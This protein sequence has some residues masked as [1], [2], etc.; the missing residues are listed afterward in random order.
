MSGAAA[1]GV[2]PVILCARIGRLACFEVY[3][4]VG[5]PNPDAL[6]TGFDNVN[7]TVPFLS[8]PLVHQLRPSIVSFAELATQ[9]CARGQFEPRAV[10]CFVGEHKPEREVLPE[11]DI[12][13]LRVE[14][15]MGWLERSPW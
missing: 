3:T 8:P 9:S 10:A 1:V 7:K 6:G 2:K 12:S 15:G 14:V 13:L 4:E 11:D 5:P